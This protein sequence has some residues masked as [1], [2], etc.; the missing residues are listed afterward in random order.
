MRALSSHLIGGALLGAA[1]FG[2]PA[3]HAGD[4]DTA[5]RLLGFLTFVSEYCPDLRANK[6]AFAA[7]I[8]R[9]GV[10]ATELQS[11][12]FNL[13]SAALIADFVKH[14]HS[15]C[16]VALVAFGPSG[17]VQPDLVATR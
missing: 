14:R 6:T 12:A 4:T 13:Q 15:A 16:T 1:V 9:T 7:A 2:A 5:A 11:D 3:A 8:Y 10:S 17:T